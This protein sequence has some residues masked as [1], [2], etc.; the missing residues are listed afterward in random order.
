MYVKELLAEENDERDDGFEDSFI[1]VRFSD[2]TVSMQLIV[3]GKSAALSITSITVWPDSIFWVWVRLIFHPV[4]S[5]FFKEFLSNFALF[6]AL[7][8]FVCT[9][10]ELFAFRKSMVSASELKDWIRTCGKIV[11]LVD[12]GLRM[13]AK[14]KVTWVFDG[15][16]DTLFVNLT[17]VVLRNENGMSWEVIELVDILTEVTWLKSSSESKLTLK[18]PLTSREFSITNCRVYVVSS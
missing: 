9:K 17:A 3:D 4:N 2:V 6:I 15:I 5:S 16:L 14:V 11:G 1:H 10:M 13:F 12:D 7:T 8:V 18:Y